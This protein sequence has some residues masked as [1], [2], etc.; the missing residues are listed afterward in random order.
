MLTA[1]LF[2]CLVLELSI[3]IRRTDFGVLKT[4]TVQAQKISI[5]LTMLNQQTYRRLA[6]PNTI[7]FRVQGWTRKAI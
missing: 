1:A 6:L 5:L 7:A 3:F 2:S 4:L